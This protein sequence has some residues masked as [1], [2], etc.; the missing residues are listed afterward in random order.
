MTDPTQLARGIA[1]DKAD[2]LE[3]EDYEALIEAIAAALREA[4]ERGRSEEF[5]NNVSH[6]EAAEKQAEAEGYRR[7]L[8]EGL[9]RQ[10]GA[11]YQK[12]ESDGYR[13]GVEEAF[14]FVSIFSSDHTT[15]CAYVNRP[16]AYC[17]CMLP[18]KIRSV[19]ELQRGT[20]GSK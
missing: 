14:R 10:Q 4:Y 1:S 8:E 17:S 9:E 3:Q 15:R 6:C 13:R 5:K 12:G 2:Y 18:E 16:R 11:I 7:G 20:G 19:Y